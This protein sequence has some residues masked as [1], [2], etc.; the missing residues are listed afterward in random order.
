M[1]TDLQVMSRLKKVIPEVEKKKQELKNK[2]LEEQE[3]MFTNDKVP[4]LSNW[5]VIRP[6]LSNDFVVDD[7]NLLIPP[8]IG[9]LICQFKINAYGLLLRM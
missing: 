5:S 9:E 4:Q 7:N 3:D 1:S 2:R 6:Y 8:T